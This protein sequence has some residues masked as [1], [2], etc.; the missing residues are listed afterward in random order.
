MVLVLIVKTLLLLIVCVAIAAGWALNRA[1]ATRLRAELD[2]LRR[3]NS[4]LGTARHEHERLRE[5]RAAAM[6][7]K[8]E[9][10]PVAPAEAPVRSEPRVALVTGE[11][12]P[13]V[14]W[15]NRGQATPLAT[16]ETALW[17][18]AGGDLGV[19]KNLLQLDDAERAQA[20][21]LHAKL[22]LDARATYPSAEQLLAAFATKSLPLGDAQVVWHHQPSDDEAFACLFVKNH[23]PSPAPAIS[24]PIPS[25]QKP[26]P[27][28]APNSATRALYLNLRRS[29]DGWRLAVSPGAVNKIAR[30]IS[31]GK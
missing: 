9:P 14:A 30:E 28:A 8:R 19:L 3:E 21:A 2:A 13:S 7:R 29:E 26:P 25:G 11:W 20:E 12:H 15:R 27:M 10:M 1:A 4:S 31:G 18:A 6:L 16:I 23:E 17:A 5:A 22:P 24:E